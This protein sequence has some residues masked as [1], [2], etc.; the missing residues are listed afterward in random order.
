MEVNNM[1]VNDIEVNDILAEMKTEEF[2]AEAE[3]KKI[4]EEK[5]EVK[6]ENKK[7]EAKAFEKKNK[8]NKQN[9]MDKETRNFFIKNVGLMAATVV[10]GYF[11][12]ATP[13][14]CI[15]VGI[16]CACGFS[17]KCGEVKGRMS[18]G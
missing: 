11:K 2:I 13:I 9:K 4:I 8:N 10:C 18:N 17:Y 3:D 12:L 15:I 6:M 5:K 1:E 16:I 7:N 14:L